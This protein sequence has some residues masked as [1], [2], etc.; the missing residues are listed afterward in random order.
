MP[1]HQN[2]NQIQKCEQGHSI[3]KESCTSCKKIKS[4]WDEYLKSCG[5]V[6]IEKTNRHVDLGSTADLGERTAFKNKITFEAKQN[7]FIWASQM[8]NVGKFES[9]NHQVIWELHADGFTSREIAP[10]IGLDQSN[11]V[12]AIKRIENYLKGVTASNYSCLSYFL[13]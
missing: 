11:V 10:V 1:H 9:V 3:F 7:Y 4:E 13:F 2:N 5:F 8:L 6:D 12:R